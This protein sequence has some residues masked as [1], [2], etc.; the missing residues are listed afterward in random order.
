MC[1]FLCLY[2]SLSLSLSPPL[3][4]SLSHL[5]ASPPPLCLTI[6]L[7]SV[8]FI[9]RYE[10]IAFT[11]KLFSNNASIQREATLQANA[12]SEL[13]ELRDALKEIIKQH[14]E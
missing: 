5:P 3:S 6:C 13:E 9:P 1:V 10:S 2:P 14:R 11:L 4:L 12:I 7:N 8:L